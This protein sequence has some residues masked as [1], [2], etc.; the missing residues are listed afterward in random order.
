MRAERAAEQLKV[1]RQLMER[2]IRFSTMSGR[3]GILAGGLALVGCWLDAYVTTHFGRHEAT[4]INLVVWAGVFLAAF[5]AVV[6]CTRLQERRQ[7]LPFWSPVKRKILLTILPGFVAGVGLTLVIVFR[8]YYGIGPNQWGLILPMWMA[9]YGVTLWQLG[10]FAPVEVRVL[11][12]AF[13]AAALVTAAQFQ[14]DPYPPMAVTFGG[15]HI[16]YGI[17]VWIRHGG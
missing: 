2:P 17:V 5:A 15:F 9:F 16:L 6:V 4:R 13:I 11:G 8:W 3:S 10:A 1:I 14:Y 12:A 7:N